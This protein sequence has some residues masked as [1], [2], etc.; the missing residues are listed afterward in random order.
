MDA[1]IILRANEPAGPVTY[2]F[3][4]G[5]RLLSVNDQPV[6]KEEHSDLGEILIQYAEWPDGIG[7]LTLTEP[8]TGKHVNLTVA[9]QG[10]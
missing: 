6:P 9:P 10:N 1:N 5:G 8:T 7:E 2:K 4:K 3:A